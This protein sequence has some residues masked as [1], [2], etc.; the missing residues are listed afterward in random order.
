MEFFTRK[1]ISTTILAY[2]Q[3]GSGKTHTLFGHKQK[4]QKGLIHF[5]VEDLLSHT[6]AQGLTPRLSFMQIYKEKASDLTTSAPVLLKENGSGELLLENL[7]V[8]EGADREQLLALLER[9]HANKIFGN[10]YLNSES[11]RSH[12]VF[13]IEVQGCKLHIVDLCGSEV[14]TY[15]FNEQQR[16]ETNSINLSLFTL[17]AVL[18]DLAAPKAAQKF[19]PFRNSVLTRG[20]QESL[21]DSKKSQIYLA[22]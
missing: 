16:E 5:I 3:T 4:E 14:L 21:I 20:L 13:T 9:A 2:G 8:Y 11:S 10:S 1:G 15:E 19:I 18:S 17:N 7:R 22:E 12:V 6:Q